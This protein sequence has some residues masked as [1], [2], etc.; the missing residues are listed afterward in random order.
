MAPEA[1]ATSEGNGTIVAVIDSGVAYN[2][3]DLINSMWNGSNCKDE[4]GAALG[5]C[6]S[7]FDYE[8]G[9]KIPLPSTSSHGTHIAGTIAAV[10]NNSKGIIG[11][12]PLTKIMAIKSS[13]TTTDNVKSINFAQQNGAKIINAS[14]AGTYD[15]TSLKMR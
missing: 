12:A 10:K 15:D 8:D 2:H 7:G 14:W 13:L 9:D 4:N 11:V 1:W 5:G 3:P 6:N